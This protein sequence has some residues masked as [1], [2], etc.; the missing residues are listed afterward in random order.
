MTI[1]DRYLTSRLL[2]TLAKIVLTLAGLFILIDLLVTQQSII[3]RNQIPLLIVAEYYLTQLPVILFTYHAVALGLLIAALMVLGRAAQDQEITA[4]LAGGISLRR[5]AAGPLAVGLFMSVL[6]FGLQE[7][8]GVQAATRGVALNNEYFKRS[9]GNVRE[10]VSWAGLSDGWTC[11]ILKFN[12]AALTGE[13]VFLHRIADDQFDDI[14]ADRIYWDETRSIWLLE[15]GRRFSFDLAQSWEQRVTRIT[16]APAPFGE[17]PEV[18]FVLEDP[19][20][21]KPFTQLSQDL[22]RAEALGMPVQRQWV[23]FHAKFA[24]PALCFIMVLLAVPFALRIRRGGLAVSFGVAIG[25]GFAY[26]LVFLVGIGLGW[27]N[28]L[29]PVVAAWLANGIFF[30]G[31]SWLLFRSPT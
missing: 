19:A 25:L 3:G 17:S 2:S 20:A 16:Q 12:R 15:N 13:D 5:I 27:M 31:G 28:V 26:M 1:L 18:L 10:G 29:P 14:R 4:T 9:S 7:T 24:Q 11:H 6:V 23:D 8:W 30:V 21:S 22:Q